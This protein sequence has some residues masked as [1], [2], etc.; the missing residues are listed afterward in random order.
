MLNRLF[1]I[2]LWGV[3]GIT[4]VIM[5]INAVY[6]FISPR[7]W[8]ALPGWLRLQGVLTVR[9]Y[10]AGAGALQVRALGAIIIATMVWVLIDILPA[11]HKK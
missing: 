11:I 9:K 2:G 6:M 3:L 10:G 7:A 5:L 1:Q 8:F 4:L